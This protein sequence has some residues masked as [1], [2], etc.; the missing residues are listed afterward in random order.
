[1][2]QSYDSFDTKEVTNRFILQKF[3]TKKVDEATVSPNQYFF[4]VFRSY[5]K[6]HF[7]PLNLPQ[8]PSVFALL[9]DDN[10]F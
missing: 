4:E 6:P 5:S 2:N 10:L 1:M 9:G 7:I 3:S 8:D